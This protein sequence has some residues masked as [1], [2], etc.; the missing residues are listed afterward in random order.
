MPQVAWSTESSRQSPAVR[1]Q[2]AYS[3]LSR[4]VPSSRDQLMMG[5]S[6]SS[7]AR[8][9]PA[10][11]HAAYLTGFRQHGNG[12]TSIIYPSA[13]I[14]PCFPS[15]NNEQVSYTDWRNFFYCQKKPPNPKHSSSLFVW[16]LLLKRFFSV[17]LK[18]YVT[19]N[20]LLKVFKSSTNLISMTS[21]DSILPLPHK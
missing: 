1:F 13:Q 5:D 10:L 21:T 14:K 18:N 15:Y 12:I 20:W 6:S 16:G 17:F 11:K 8:A 4:R 7:S 9:Q 3:L 2:S 19:P